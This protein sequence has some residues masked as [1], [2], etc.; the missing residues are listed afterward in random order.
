M[1]NTV[2]LFV[3]SDFSVLNLTFILSSLP[4]LDFNRVG[5]NSYIVRH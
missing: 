2:N 5:I 1:I 4:N 3:C